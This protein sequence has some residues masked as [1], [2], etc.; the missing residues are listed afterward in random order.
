MCT[1]IVSVVYIVYYF[2]TVTYLSILQAVSYQDVKARVT[3]SIYLSEYVWKWMK[4]ESR[5]HFAKL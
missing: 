3:V 5:V 4:E 1:C 2:I